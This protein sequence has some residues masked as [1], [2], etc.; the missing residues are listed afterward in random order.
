MLLRQVVPIAGF[1]AASIVGS[2][3]DA[4][5]LK[6]VDQ[7]DPRLERLK[8]FFGKLDCPLKSS[9]EE[10]LIAADENDLDWR[11]LPSISFVE[12]SGGKDYKNN[13]VLGWDSCREKFETVEAGIHYVAAQLA[14][15]KLYKDKT[16][17]GKLRTYN[18]RPEYGQLVRQVMRILGPSGLGSAIAAD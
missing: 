16:L 10:F 9:A 18:P 3:N 12:S 11:L 17:E 15:S 4:I 13:N 2:S 8:Q 1:L 5:Q 6:E 14:N 7:N